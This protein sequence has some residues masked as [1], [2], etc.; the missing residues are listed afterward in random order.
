MF[1]K[2]QPTFLSKVGRQGAPEV[3]APFAKKTTKASAS[4]MAAGNGKN[5]AKATKKV[6]KNGAPLKTGKVKP[7][8]N[9]KTGKKAN[10]KLKGKP[11]VDK[12][13][14]NYFMRFSPKLTSATN[15]PQTAPQAYKPRG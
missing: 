7:N 2:A 5:T 6:V 11:S 15:S 10:F 13:L 9:A 14:S 3:I 12:R 4:K 8:V 1:K